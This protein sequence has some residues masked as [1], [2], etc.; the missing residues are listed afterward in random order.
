M[1]NSSLLILILLSA[2]A[3]DTHTLVSWL[4]EHPVEVE[5]VAAAG[6][7]RE[8]DPQ[9]PEDVTVIEDDTPK[10]KE[11]D[12]RLSFPVS[13]SVTSLLLRCSQ[14]RCPPQLRSESHL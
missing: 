13:H 10:D 3:T 11:E 2:G 7:R 1:F 8:R 9:K 6:A 5:H 4:M 12:A 14:N